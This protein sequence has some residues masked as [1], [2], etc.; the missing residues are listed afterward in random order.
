MATN[1]NRTGVFL[2][3]KFRIEHG[4]FAGSD[5]TRVAPVSGWRRR[6][7]ATESG[8]ALG[9]GNMRAP[10]CESLTE[11]RIGKRAPSRPAG[12]R[13]TIWPSSTDSGTVRGWATRTI[14]GTTVPGGSVRKV[15]DQGNKGSQGRFRTYETVT[16]G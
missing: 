14:G 4:F 8:G 16:S 2:M 15:T 12:N 7:G 10:Y 3:T 13:A 5:Q 6:I 11:V 1:L 9:S